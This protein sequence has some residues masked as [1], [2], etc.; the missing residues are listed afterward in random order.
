M[1]KLSD[2]KLLA[3]F[4]ADE[5]VNNANALLRHI[6]D[7]QV[8]KR[9]L[10][11]YSSQG[12]LP[13]PEGPRSQARYSYEH[14]VILV[15]L[16]VFKYLGMR[17][18]RIEGMIRNQRL[19]G[20]EKL[21]ETVQ[22]YLDKAKEEE[23]PPDLQDHDSAIRAFADSFRL[24]VAANVVRPFSKFLTRHVFSSA[25]ETQPDMKKVMRVE[26]APDITLEFPEHMSLRTALQ[27]AY[28]KLQKLLDEL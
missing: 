7:A 22:R 20:I 9:T 6:P 15:A 23:Y 27:E 21:E 19:G 12:L 14:L 11:F 25:P 8:Q 4:T 17:L 28:S 24:P 2:Y 1:P 18:D 13:P 26:L 5:L 16:R 10:R 3:P